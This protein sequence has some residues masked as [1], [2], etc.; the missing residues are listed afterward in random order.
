[1]ELHEIRYFLAVTEARNFTAAARLCHVSQPALTRAIQKLEGEMGG[2]LFR[3]DR[4]G[5]ALTDLGRLLLPHLQ[6]VAARTEAA[7]QSASRFL[8][9]EGAELKLGVMC[10]IGPL[11][12]IGFLNRF[13]GGHPG[14]ETTLL[15]ATPARLGE[16][17]L[18][19]TLDV[20]V[21]A[22]RD[23]F[24]DRFR[25]I[26]LYPERFVVACPLGHRFERRSEVAMRDMAGET[27]LSRI[28]CEYQDH[29]SAALREVGVDVVRSYRSEREDWIQTMVAAG[30]G[31][32][33]L[34]E[35]SIIVPGLVMRPLVS[36]RVARQVCL[37]TVAGRRWSAPVG[38][39]IQ[40]IRRHNWPENTEEVLEEA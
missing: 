16:L 7:R 5:V 22:S 11:R 24:D 39:F 25:S 1:M 15:E 2:L 17:L 12:F 32:C 26:P 29:L 40:A 4:A 14:I 21:M 8:R 36:P 34:P 31:V 33:F 28:N 13:R 19:G 18:E 6:E 30:M 3:R 38:S 35:Y 20:A 10:T 27:Y 9:L 37:V 23:G